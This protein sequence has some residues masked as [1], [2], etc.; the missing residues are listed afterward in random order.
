[1][2]TLCCRDHFSPKKRGG[3]RSLHEV[4][5]MM[6]Q[7]AYAEFFPVRPVLSCYA[8]VQFVI[9]LFLYRPS[10]MLVGREKHMPSPPLRATRGDTKPP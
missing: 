6:V 8:I 2:T 10:H 7:C 1:M 9:T 5:N 4:M 3:T